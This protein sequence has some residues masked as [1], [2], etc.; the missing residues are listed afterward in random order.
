VYNTEQIYANCRAV[1][2]RQRQKPSLQWIL[3]AQNRALDNPVQHDAHKTGQHRRYEPRRHNCAQR[4]KLDAVRAARH[5]TKPN[6]R[7][8]NAVRTRY[9]Q[10]HEC[11]HQQP[12]GTAR[13][14]RQTAQHQFPFV[15]MVQ[16]DIE[17]AFSHRV[18][19]FVAWNT[20]ETPSRL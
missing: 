4:L 3:G 10:F 1:E 2:Q 6:R 5:Q 17:D 11:G 19:H 7:S 18:R 9:R 14:R 15:A 12:K 13:Q 20:K 16:F 8:N